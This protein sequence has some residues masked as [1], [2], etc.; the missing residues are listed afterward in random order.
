MKRQGVH[1]N[2]RDETAEW[3]AVITEVTTPPSQGSM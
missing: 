3:E 1:R 2:L